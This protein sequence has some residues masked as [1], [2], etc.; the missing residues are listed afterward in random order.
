MAEQNTGC[1]VEDTIAAIATPPG[2]GGIG[3]VRVSG[4]SAHALGLRLFLSRSPAFYDFVPRFFHYGQLVAR[5]ENG[6]RLLDEGMVV[7]MPGPASFTGEDVVEFHCHGSPPVLE[8]VLLELLANGARLAQRG[9]FTRRAFMNG[10]MDLTQAEAVAELIAAQNEKAAALAGERLKGRLGGQ[11]HSLREALD[12]LRSRLV[13][14][15]DFP[16]EETDIL[17]AEAI[18]ASTKS[19]LASLKDLLAAY[20]R[21]HIWESEVSLILVGPVNAGKS[22]LFNALLGKRRALVSP[23]AGT[24]RDYLKEPFV[25]GGLSISLVDTA[26]W[27]STP[28]ALEAEGMDMGLEKIEHADLVLLV[29]DAVE[30]KKKVRCASS[31]PSLMDWLAR[32]GLERFSSR[33]LGRPLLGVANKQDQIE[34]K[35][36]QQIALCRDVEWIGTSAKTGAGIENLLEAVQKRLIHQ[37]EFVAEEI[38]PNL[39][40]SVA[41]G[42]AGKELELLLE[43]VAQGVP[44]DILGVRVETAARLLD[45]VTGVSTSAEILEKIFSAFCIGK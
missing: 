28:D 14:T 45:E 43:D 20:E 10:R 39:R 15:V 21:S 8:S 6:I 38:A 42:E 41:L 22:S 29:A 17:P 35:G 40:Q 30:E 27:R 36:E 34:E 9:E 11:I 24:T 26:G 12:E 23:Q 33:L 2:H 44:H 1:L 7:F 4:P 25:L 18:V 32:A 19:I 13:A 16:D 37:S 31:L 3:I 5:Q